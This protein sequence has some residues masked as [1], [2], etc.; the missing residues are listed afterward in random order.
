M[1]AHHHFRSLFQLSLRDMLFKSLMSGLAHRVCMPATGK[2]SS[3]QPGD[4]V[5]FTRALII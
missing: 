3:I 1:V 5:V 2:I 4:I